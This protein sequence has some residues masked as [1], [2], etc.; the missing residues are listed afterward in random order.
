[1]SV[2]ISVVRMAPGVD[3]I[4]LASRIGRR[5]LCRQGRVGDAV[6]YLSVGIVAVGSVEEVIVGV[7][8]TVW[9][10]LVAVDYKVLITV[11]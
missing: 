5:S 7:V 4:G 10:D 11:C 3:D 8:V 1:V 9:S 6:E 2:T